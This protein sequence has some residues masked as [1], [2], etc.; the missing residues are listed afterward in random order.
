M[1]STRKYVYYPAAYFA[2]LAI[3]IS[4]E[5]SGGLVRSPFTAVFFA[6]I[7]GAQQLSR[8]K[9][10]SRIFIVFA[11]IS[12]T[13]LGLYES[14]VGIP[15]QPAPPVELNFYILAASLFV[16]AMCT[17]AAK[18]INYRARGT[19]PDPT[20]AEV[21]KSTGDDLWRFALYHR[22]TRLDSVLNVKLGS[23]IHEAQAEVAAAALGLCAETKSQIEWRAQRDHS[24]ALGYI[25]PVIAADA[26][27]TGTNLEQSS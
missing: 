13:V 2:F 3:A 27:A 6:M 23:S 12:T 10:N 4:V 5:I 21:Y 19:Y 24:E 17:H 14:A 26:E 9:L 25:R 8:Y 22:S 15:S 11:V 1:T 7:L 18:P 20:H 16:T